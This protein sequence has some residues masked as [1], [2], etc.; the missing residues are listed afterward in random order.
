MLTFPDGTVLNR[1]L[2]KQKFYEKLN[3]SSKLEQQFVKEIDTIYWRYKL[4]QETLNVSKGKDVTEIEV[5]EIKLKEQCI[6]R[7][8]I[9][10]I[11]R[12]LPYHI[13]FILRYQ[14]LGQIWISY[15]TSSRSRKDRFKIDTY[16]TTE[17]ML[18]EDLILEINGL[19]LDKIYENF[20]IQVAGDR[21]QIESE[22]DIKV[23][24]DRAKEKEKLERAIRILENKIRNEKQFNLQVKLMGEL[25][26]LKNTLNKNFG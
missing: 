25:R 8:I 22:E 24:I 1:R 19:D 16:Y 14:D 21:L 23:A 6:S 13:V 11:D 7:D 5:L 4:A 10:L 3:I 2:P 15:K 9:E 17:W 20:I 18:Y 12:G 26:K